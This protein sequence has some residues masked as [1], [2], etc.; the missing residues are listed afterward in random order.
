MS[1]IGSTGD[2]LSALDMRAITPTFAI[3]RHFCQ[4]RGFSSG[5]SSIRRSCVVSWVRV[6]AL[7]AH[8]ARDSPSSLNRSSSNGACSPRDMITLHGIW[9]VRDVLKKDCRVA[10]INRWVPNMSLETVVIIVS[11]L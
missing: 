1:V 10:L 9:C 2:E 7:S 4:L 8:T 6:Y 3:F 11:T 5:K